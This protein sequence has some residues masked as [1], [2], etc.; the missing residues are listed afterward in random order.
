MKKTIYIIPILILS[1]FIAQ[2]TYATGGG[3]YNQPLSDT[4]C[5]GTNGALIQII[6]PTKDLIYDTFKLYNN[7]TTSTDVTIGLYILKSATTTWNQTDITGWTYIVNGISGTQY[8]GEDFVIINFTEFTADGGYYAIQIDNTNIRPGITAPCLTNSTGISDTEAELWNTNTT[9]DWDHINTKTQL[10]FALYPSRVWDDAQISDLITTYQSPYFQDLD[11]SATS[12]AFYVDCSM[13]DGGFF[14][15]STVNGLVCG[16]KKIAFQIIGWL[17]VPPKNI[18]NEF[19]SSW[20]SIKT[21]F[22]FNVIYE[23]SETTQEI[24]NTEASSTTANTWSVSIKNT[25]FTLLTS[26]TLESVMGSST[27]AQVF[28]FL[29]NFIW[30]GTGAIILFTVL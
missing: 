4:I 24:A 7:G 1:F 26:T 30:L 29:E 25:N 12:S 20:N 15:S 16:L 14:T 22:P 9:N 3:I 6:Q 19:T 18:L 17:I 23:T 2:K 11:V 21:V 8:A 5:T 13:H 10:S 28:E 27:K